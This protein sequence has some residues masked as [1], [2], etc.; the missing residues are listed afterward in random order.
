MIRRL[1]PAAVRAALADGGEIALIDVREEGVFGQG[2]LFYACCIP[3][4]RLELRIA[5]LVPRRSAR[6]VLVDGGEGLAERAGARLAASGYGDVAVLAGGTPAWAGAG[7]EVFS[8]VNVPSKA[9]GE[10]VEHAYDTPRIPAKELK[11]RMDAGEDLIVVDSRPMEEYRRMNIPTG[12]DLPG[13]ELLYRIADMV[14]SPDTLVVVNCAGR[15]RSIIGAQ[16]LINAGIANRVVALK[17]G[18]MGWTLAGFD[19]ETG[20][21]RRGPEVSAEGLARARTQAARVAARFGVRRIDRAQ[22]AAWRREADQRTLY[23]LDVRRPEEFRAGHLPGTR[24]APGGQLVQTT[25]AFAATRG[26]RIV[27]VDDTEVRATMTASWLIQMGWPEVAV[28]EGGIGLDG[29]V[30]GDSVPTVLG[31]DGLRVEEVAPAA[32]APALAGG[33]VAVIDL[34]D[35]RGYLA[36][37]IP[38]A[39]FALRARLGEAA[40]RLPVVGDYVL[41][42]TPD[43]VL[44]RLAAPELAQAVKGRVRVLRGGTRAWAAAGL[45]LAQGPE[46]LLESA[47]DDVFLQPYRRAG[48]VAQAMRDYL[49]WEV[50][51]VHQI[52]REGVRYP[53]YPSPA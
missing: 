34:G 52:E 42:G 27:L 7:C 38:G 10:F 8:G 44:A 16:S 48:D 21:G 26:A 43:D 47:D 41:T 37:H 12:I 15:T 35:S 31:L 2:H 45:P 11:A 24:G 17:D 20:M 19:L 51:L 40:P 32:L 49:T 9:F 5:D 46:R 50:D 28:L 36:G 1:A 13:G 29:L 39:Y 33:G 30:P 3:L 22:L 4:S 25:D 23:L 53:I 6:V 18:T 14:L